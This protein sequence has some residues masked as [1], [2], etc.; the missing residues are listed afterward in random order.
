MEIKEEEDIFGVKHIIV[1][2]TVKGD[3]L[4]IFVEGWAERKLYE[5]TFYQRVGDQ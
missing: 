2:S 1:S 4:P 3:T 5:G